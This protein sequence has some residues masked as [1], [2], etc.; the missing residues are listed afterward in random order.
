M[1]ASDVRYCHVSPI[2]VSSTHRNQ[3]YIAALER[4]AC[5]VVATD[6]HRGPADDL[7]EAEEDFTQNLSSAIFRSQSSP[8]QRSRVDYAYPEKSIC[9]RCHRYQR[10]QKL[11][12][13]IGSVHT[14]DEL[15][16]DRHRVHL[17]PLLLPLLND[18]LRTARCK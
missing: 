10:T 4:H 5:F 14:L 8:V 9:Q 11:I 13:T 16:G 12:E 17:L 15:L 1:T 6:S 18:A 7:T 3:T 2:S